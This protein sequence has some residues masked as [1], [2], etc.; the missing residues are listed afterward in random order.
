[1][2]YSRIGKSFPLFGSFADV[3]NRMHKIIII[4][5]AQVVILVNI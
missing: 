1:M 3:I 2:T 4:I 5:A